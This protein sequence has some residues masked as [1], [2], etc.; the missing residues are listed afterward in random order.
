MALAERPGCFAMQADKIGVQLGEDMLQYPRSKQI[1]SVV[2]GKKS[3]FLTMAANAH[4]QCLMLAATVDLE[5]IV[6]GAVL[7]PMPTG[8]A[9]MGNRVSTETFEPGPILF[10]NEIGR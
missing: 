4:G 7:V 6:T 8:C 2:M 3:I 9:A 5:D 1:A 10:A